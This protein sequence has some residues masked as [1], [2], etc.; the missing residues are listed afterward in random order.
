MLSAVIIARDEG[1]RIAAAIRSVAFADEVLVLDSGSLDDTVEQARQAG[2]RVLRTDWPGHVAQKNRAL[3]EARGEWILSLDADEVLDQHA[4][5]AVQHA[6]TTNSSVNGYRL[7]RQ[8]VW[9]GHAVRHG[10]WRPR[11]HLRL[12]RRTHARW[13]GEDPHDRLIVTGPV[14]TL[15]GRIV[16]TPYR[17]LGEHLATIDRYTRQQAR[18]GGPF[19]ILGRPAWHFLRGY[20]GHGGLLDGWPGLVLATLGSVHTLLKWSRGHWDPRA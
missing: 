6:L 18:R 7:R 14:S 19:D 17:H 11:P 13:V 8:E 5:A 2:A 16:H 20:L 9:L 10:H 1:D 15:P 3:A 4:A 12:A